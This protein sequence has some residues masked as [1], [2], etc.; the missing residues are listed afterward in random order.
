MPRRSEPGRRTVQQLRGQNSTKNLIC[1]I[2]GCQR[3][4]MKVFE[5]EGLTSVPEVVIQVNVVRRGDH[6]TRR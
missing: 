1:S 3:S 5:R 6:I 4:S 2:S